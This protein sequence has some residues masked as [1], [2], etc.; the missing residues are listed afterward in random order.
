MVREEL[1]NYQRIRN[2]IKERGFL[3]SSI[4]ALEFIRWAVIYSSRLIRYKLLRAIL[5]GD[6]IIKEVQGSQMIVDFKDKGISIDMYFRGEREVD[7]TREM[8]RIVKKGDTILD[9][10]ANIGYYALMESKLVGENGKVYA[11]EPAPENF[12]VLKANVIFNDYKNIELF[13]FLVGDKNGKEKLYLAS[14][15]NLHS[16][17]KGHPKATGEYIELPMVKLDDFIKGKRF[18]DLIRTDV[19]GYEYYILK[20]MKNIL[21]SKKPLKLFIEIHSRMGEKKMKEFLDTIENAGFQIVSNQPNHHPKIRTFKDLFE[22]EKRLIKKK[23]C[24]RVLFERK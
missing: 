9:V 5:R 7:S 16:V 3:K 22:Y 14:H 10:G 2:S 19:E 12:R 21:N 18:P 6:Y 1:P 8:K 11:I 20:G 13:N 17:I 15:R 23:T 24:M 4:K